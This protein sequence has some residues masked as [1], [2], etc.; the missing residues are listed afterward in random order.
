MRL[1]QIASAHVDSNALEAATYIGDARAALS[2]AANV[3][4]AAENVTAL[5]GVASTVL[6]VIPIVGTIV[7]L[8]GAI[9]GLAETAPA[10]PAG[11]EF[12]AM[13]TNGSMR[14]IDATV[15][16]EFIT[17]L[18][19]ATDLPGDVKLSSMIGQILG[20][21]QP[22]I[23]PAS[24]QP[25]IAS[26]V[27]QSQNQTED[28]FAYASFK[29]TP[30]IAYYNEWTT[31]PASHFQAA[32]TPAAT[33]LTGPNMIHGAEGPHYY[34]Q[35]FTQTNAL[36]SSL[37]SSGAYAEQIERAI[38][39]VRTMQILT[40]RDYT[41]AL[42]ILMARNPNF[43]DWVNYRAKK[44]GYVQNYIAPIR[45]Q[46]L[47]PGSLTDVQ[48]GSRYT[49][50]IGDSAA[51]YGD[52]VLTTGNPPPRRYRGYHNANPSRLRQRKYDECTRCTDSTPERQNYSF[53]RDGALK[54][55][56][57]YRSNMMRIG[58]GTLPIGVHGETIIDQLPFDIT[59]SRDQ[60][61]ARAQIA[62]S[63]EVA[64]VMDET[65]KMGLTHEQVHD[66]GVFLTTEGLPALS[67][68]SDKLYTT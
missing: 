32:V 30:G 27:P 65:Y 60:V 8:V 18:V 34:Q 62:L 13:V 7:G 41:P 51:E 67:A 39:W 21:G 2:I 5:A 26:N 6:S 57:I 43:N 42:R 66:M 47:P 55:G 14:V 23:D 68:L 19:A 64:H 11:Y 50:T 20:F 54:E 58:V 28:P 36:V 31:Q 38:G 24:N 59:I 45:Q 29:P 4:K 17:Q 12:W 56:E 46:T 61:P 52:H 15:T 35:L 16:D 40:G 33:V 3:A 37:R 63:H 1:P 53:W 9:F 44:I 49:R 10:L 48:P 22:I 25:I